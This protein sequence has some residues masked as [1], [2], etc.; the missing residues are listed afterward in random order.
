M[1]QGPVQMPFFQEASPDPPGNKQLPGSPG[2]G[3]QTGHAEGA[4]SLCQGPAPQAP[5]GQ[6]GGSAAVQAMGTQGKE[7]GGRA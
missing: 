3:S 1:T 7:Q 2:D 6:E 5:A 4:Q